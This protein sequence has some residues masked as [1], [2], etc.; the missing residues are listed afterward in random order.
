MTRSI[1]F[2]LCIVLFLNVS[3]VAVDDKVR[4]ED[5]VLKHLE[6]IGTEQARRPTRSRIVAGSSLMNLRTGGRG[7]V[8][9]PA[10]IASHEDKVL[11]KAEF[12]TASYPFE[13]LG[14]DGDKFSARQY[15]PG[16][17]SPLAQFFMSHDAI[18]SEGLIG[19]VLSSAWPLLNISERQPKLQYVGT[20][21]I[22]GRQAHKVRYTPRDGGELKIG[23]FFDA[24]NFQHLRT[25]YE[26]V[27]P[28]PL[29]ATP[30]ESA[31][32]RETRY[33]LVEDFSDFKQEGDLT[34]PHTYNLQFT[35]SQLN[36]SLALDWTITLTRFTFDY[37]IDA[38]EFVVDN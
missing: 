31:S 21:K 15:A 18:F 25:D 19:G 28:A 16:Q 8:S 33:K 12:T 4:V 13:K 20:E 35:V 6:A 24:E 34:L 9:G 3:A 10:L 38:K 7:N 26:R 36:N 32:Q 1:V 27:I 14:F 23:L 37:K 22:K 30:G 11:L 2:I 29:G 5:V 17:R